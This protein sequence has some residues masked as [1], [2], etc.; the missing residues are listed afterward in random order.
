[1][2][3]ALKYKYRN[4]LLYS[5]RVF[6]ILYTVKAL[7][8]RTKGSRLYENQRK[9]QKRA[10]QAGLDAGAACGIPE[11]SCLGG[12]PMGERQNNAGHRAAAPRSRRC[13]A[14]RRTSFWASTPSIPSRPSTPTNRS[15]R[16]CGGRET[17]P[18]CCVSGAR[19]RSATRRITT[20]CAIWRTHCCIRCIAARS[21]LRMR[22][23]PRN[24]PRCAS[25]SCATAPTLKSAVRSYR[26][27]YISHKPECAGRRRAEG[28][29]LCL[30]AAV[31]LPFAGTADGGRLLHGGRSGKSACDPA[32]AHADLNRPALPQPAVPPAGGRLDRA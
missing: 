29:R 7:S 12:L 5:E 25:A 30:Y 32:P 6:V 10:P 21:P 26:Q 16:S 22:T 24:A 8:H 1:M 28:R 31:A 9:H 2:E 20:V 18:A 11:P 3:A 17:S 13:S 27:R 23:M 19:P 15:R 4:T 14:S